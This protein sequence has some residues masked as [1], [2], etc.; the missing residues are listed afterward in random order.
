MPAEIHT[1][2][3]T[4]ECN[5]SE[6][7]THGRR[8]EFHHGEYCSNECEQRQQG[9]EVTRALRF[10]H[11]WCF[12]CYQRLKEINPPK[13]DFEFT[14]NGH[15]WTRDADGNI[16]LQYYSQEVTRT[17]AVGF[18]FLTEFAGKGE[19]QRDERVIT[20]T[21]CEHCGTT[22]HTHHEAPAPRHVIGRLVTW[23]A[24]RD[25]NVVDPHALHRAYERTGDVDYA[26][27]VGV[28]TDS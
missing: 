20:G 8:W 6:C 27:G 21:I 14:A 5:Y 24:E 3:P 22:D 19:K 10:D 18:E 15:G 9:R 25:D 11:R 26:V 13:P 12:T 17:A 4:V 28:S 23:L 7:D 1:R 16:T 2:S